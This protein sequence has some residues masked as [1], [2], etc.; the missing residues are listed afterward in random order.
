MPDCLLSASTTANGNTLN[1]WWTIPSGALALLVVLAL[2]TVFFVAIVIQRRSGEASFR[3][4]RMLGVLGIRIGEGRGEQRSAPRRTRCVK[5]QRAQVVMPVSR[6]PYSLEH[7]LRT[8]R[9]S[10][11]LGGQNSFWVIPPKSSKERQDLID[12]ILSFLKNGTDREFIVLM[13]DPDDKTC[14]EAWKRINPDDPNAGNYQE[15]LQAAK[16]SLEEIGRQACASSV[17]GFLGLAYDMFPFELTFVDPTEEGG[18]LTFQPIING[19]RNGDQRPQF[20]VSRSR[21]L[22]VF[23]HYL[24]R[25]RE[26][27]GRIRERKAGKRIA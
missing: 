10:I 4:P 27:V 3:L 5:P 22:L 16:E 8:A 7:A 12:S 18:Y 23:E 6:S 15:H 11:M 20:V 26:L 19:S 2:L 24:G 9:K 13:C 1:G 21:H 14:T 25:F 17:S